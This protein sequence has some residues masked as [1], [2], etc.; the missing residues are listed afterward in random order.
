MITIEGDDRSRDAEGP[1]DITLPDPREVNKQLRAERRM[2]RSCTPR[3][4]EAHA[5]KFKQVLADARQKHAGDPNAQIAYYLARTSIPAASGRKRTIGNK[6]QTEVGG[7]L[8]AMPGLLKRARMPIQNLTD[9][10]RKHVIRLVAFMSDPRG[11]ALNVRTIRDRESIMR[12]FLILAGH[13]EAVPIG[14]AWEEMLAA[15]G[16]E[17][18]PST[19]TAA[20]LPKGWR[21]MGID[22]E[23]IIE[24]VRAESPLMGTHLD[25]ELAFGLRCAETLQLQPRHADKGEYVLVARGTKGKKVREIPFS[26]DPAKRAFQRKV[27]DLAIRIAERNPKKEL[28][29][30]GRDL[31]QMTRRQR[32]VFEKHG[33]TKSALGIVPHGLRHQFATD[34]FFEL[35]GMPAPVLG[36]LPAEEYER[37]A[38]KVRAANLEIARQLGHERVSISTAYN[39]SHKRLSR[40]QA[41]LLRQRLDRLE[42]CQEWLDAA[43][44]RDCWIVGSAAEGFP[45]RRGDAVQVL[46]RFGQ[47]EPGYMES[48]TT[49]LTHRIQQVLGEPAFVSVWMGNGTPPGGAEVMYSPSTHLRAAQPSSGEAH[50][51]S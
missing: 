4:L 15:A 8:K 3:R 32:Y 41:K 7:F 42:Q 16:V 36:L 20:V 34:L 6:R 47:V 45:V 44:V 19:S 33:L 50:H 1:D 9:I 14:R 37:N 24:A 5:G 30:V 10:K 46:V 31:A 17:R 29:E 51:G 25:L 38:E 49:I 40:D 21:D 22:P 18:D 11:M 27:L 2:S 39:G 48:R 28:G 35:T 43:G 13:P 12:R 23:P 26:K